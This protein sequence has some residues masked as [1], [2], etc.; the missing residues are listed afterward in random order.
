[1]ACLEADITHLDMIEQRRKY[2][3]TSAQRKE[4]NYAKLRGFW[5]NLQL[6]FNSTVLNVCLHDVK[7]YFEPARRKY[8]KTTL[9]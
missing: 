5:L 3:Y 1:M 6:K 4:V 9:C 7:K 2:W 8:L